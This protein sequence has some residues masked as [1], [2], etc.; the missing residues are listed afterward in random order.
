MCFE[1]QACNA[2]RHTCSRQ[3]KNLSPTA[4][5]RGCQCISALQAVSDIKY[6]GAPAGCFRHLTK[7]K[8]I[9]YQVVVSERATTL[10]KNDLIVTRLDTFVGDVHDLRRAHELRF[11]HIDYPPRPGNSEQ[12][13]RLARKESRDL[14]NV[15]YLRYA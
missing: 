9:D 1:E 15:R 7:S 14:Q 6:H 8:H 11:L 10:A 4:P 3:V 13:V 2:N 12:Q 5:R